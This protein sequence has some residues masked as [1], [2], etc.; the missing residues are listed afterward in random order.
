M[1]VSVL[2]PTMGRPAQA[3]RCVNRLF[4]TVRGLDVECVCV[5]ECDPR[6][7][8]RLRKETRARV[9]ERSEHRGPVYGW[10]EAA[11]AATGD[12]FVL[13]G[14]DLDWQDG[15]LHRALSHLTPQCDFVGLNDGHR[16]GNV[17]MATHFLVT[18]QHCIEVQGGVMACPHYH[19]YALDDEATD[20]ARRAE[21]YVWA[22][23]AL[24]PH[25][26]W[27]WQTAQDD[28]TYQ[29]AR[30]WKQRDGEM[31]RMRKVAGFP[32]DWEPLF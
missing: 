19:H 4:E 9:I 8:D 5:V 31:Y 23:D 21:R 6:S 26:H 17:E 11:A 13:A 15:W 7:A 20:K 1:K 30:E 16:D 2:L 3:V 12:V 14:D 25:K 32:H 24:V 22:Q 10:N 29:K 18:R 28:A 27:Q